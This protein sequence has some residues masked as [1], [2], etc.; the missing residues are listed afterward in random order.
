MPDA[1][2]KRWQSAGVKFGM[3]LG[4]FLFLTQVS[5]VCL[6]PIFH[7]LRERAY[8]YCIISLFSIIGATVGW[9][10][11][12]VVSPRE[13]ED[14]RFAIVGSAIATFFSGFL[15]SKFDALF[16][17]FQ[18]PGSS[19]NSMPDR[20]ILIIRSAFSVAWFMFALTIT[21][22]TRTEEMDRLKLPP[23]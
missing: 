10:L 2:K 18:N 6:S 22:L 21:F 11:G 9:F 19:S 15:I 20:S 13:G 16:G 4:F 14:K 17:L 8:E 12:I 7:G 23:R 5:T 3:I 1:N